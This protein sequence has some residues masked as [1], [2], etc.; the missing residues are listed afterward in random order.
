ML[1]YGQLGEK[2]L[3][4]PINDHGKALVRTRRNE[5]QK[6]N[7]EE[8]TNQQGTTPDA[9]AEEMMADSNQQPPK[10]RG[11]VEKIDPR[12]FLPDLDKVE[13]EVEDI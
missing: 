10:D 13:V 8:R 9:V 4:F 1:S 3:R 6:F 12:K 7:V 2:C 5:E 11:S